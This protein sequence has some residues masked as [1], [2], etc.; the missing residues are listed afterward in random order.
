MSCPRKAF[1]SALPLISAFRFQLFSFTHQSPLPY[2]PHAAGDKS[3]RRKPPKACRWFGQE[4]F[5][6]CPQ[7]EKPWGGF[8]SIRPRPTGSLN[9]SSSS[10]F[11]TFICGSILFSSSSTPQPH[12]HSA[13]KWARR[14]AHALP[15]SHLR[16]SRSFD[17]LF[18]IVSSPISAALRLRLSSLPSS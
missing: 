10:A 4:L 3:A 17:S 1:Q 6:T 5:A 16:P 8:E 7:G 14:A 2:P 11:I 9:P 12:R 13:G 18:W 15:S